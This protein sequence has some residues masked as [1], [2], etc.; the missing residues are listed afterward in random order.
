MEAAQ[1]RAAQLLQ[2]VLGG[3]SLAGLAGAR[4]AVAPGDAALVQEL[5]FG[6]LRWW[7][8]I[9]A[10]ERQLFHRKP[11]RVSVR[12][13]IGVAL[14]QLLE[15]SAPPF[16]V[17][18]Q[19]VRAAEHAGLGAAKGLVN[20]V[21][22][23]FLR[24]REERLAVLAQD[25]LARY[26]HPRWWI[27][28]LKTD[29]ALEWSAALDAANTRPPLS[30]RTNERRCSRAQL[31]ELFAAQGI[32]AD[33]VGRAGLLLARPQP[34][35]QLPG[36]AEGW[37]SVQDVGAQLAAELLDPQADMRVLDACAAPGGKTTHL[38]ERSN[39][40]VLAV[41][42]EEKRLLR[43]HENLNRLGLRAEAIVGDA[44]DPRAWW[45]GRPFE[46]ILAD[47]PCSSSGVV[48]RH[49]DIKWL[50]R[51]SDLDTLA[52]QQLAIAEALWP[53]LASG[54][55]MLYATCS[56]FRAENE[57]VLERFVDHHDDAR[58]IPQAIGQ[59]RRGQL[60]P[61]AQDAAH[62]HDGFYYALLE[63]S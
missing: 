61:V 13:L 44:R 24:T 52:T 23:E 22:R 3:R 21:L 16:A 1:R 29:H 33:P 7:G 12:C 45:D 4:D 32:E 2:E 20:A 40:Q 5:V 39:C 60:L 11:P 56:V 51:E 34:V 26:S 27:E 49:P 18:D 55:R 28:R 31:Q 15:T 25:E 19:A 38:L 47:V 59:A 17:V 62:N 58:V 46:R 35:T 54:G 53:L 8:R 14:Y 6:S 50:R 30:L 63:K 9:E 36:F 43:V 10:L 57:G 42:C 37:F 41:D 48:R